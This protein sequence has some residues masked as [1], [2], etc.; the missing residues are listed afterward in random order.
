M[1]RCSVL[2]FSVAV[3]AQNNSDAKKGQASAQFSSA[4]LDRMIGAGKSPQELARYI[5]DTQGC[6]KCHT[7]G[8]DGKLGF[9]DLGNERAQGYQGCISTLTA[10]TVIAKIPEGQRSPAQRRRV[11]RFEEFGCTT[12]HK[13]AEG[14]MALTALG[15]KLANLHL[16]CVEIEKLTSS[17]N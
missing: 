14:K 5:F 16:G 7:I 3:L 13:P 2:L 12:C 10:M 8:H 17:R 11:E 15:A 6:N 4:T 1:K 9:T